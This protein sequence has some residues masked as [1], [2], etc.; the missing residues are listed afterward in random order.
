MTACLGWYQW[1]HQRSCNWSFVRGIYQRSSP[2]SV[3][4]Y[5]HPWLIVQT[6]GSWLTG[7]GEY[8]QNGKK[9]RFKTPQAV[10]LWIYR[11]PGKMPIIYQYI[12]ITFHL[13]RTFDDAF[14]ELSFAMIT[15]VSETFSVQHY[16]SPRWKL[17]FDSPYLYKFVKS[18]IS[19]IRRSHDSIYLE[20]GSLCWSNPL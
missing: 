10:W 7:S 17:H 19:K 15:W 20:K 12:T 6:S 18:N 4:Q 9:I 1:N 14:E 8:L 16:S 5:I 3:L 2:L 11:A 13:F